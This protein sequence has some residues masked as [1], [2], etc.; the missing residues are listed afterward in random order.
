MPVAM[1]LRG[2]EE[3]SASSG[4]C[5]RM[6]PPASLTARTPMAPAEPAPLRMTAKPSPSRS[7][8]ERKN[9]S[10]GLRW[11]RGSSNS[12]AETS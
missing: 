1:A 3:Y 6:M 5:T 10:I 8:T 11:P 7:A 2:I 12:S 4:F 9:R